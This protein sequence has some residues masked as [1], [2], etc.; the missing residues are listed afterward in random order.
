MR[1]RVGEVQM[2]AR[3]AGGRAY[4]LAGRP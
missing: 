4:G 2:A 1:Q 3:C